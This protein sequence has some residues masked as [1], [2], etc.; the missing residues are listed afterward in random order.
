M[1]DPLTLMIDLH[2]DIL[3]FL[4]FIIAFVLWMMGTI[5]FYFNAAYLNK[6]DLNPPSNNTV[7][8]PIIEVL[9][10]SNYTLSI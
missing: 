9:V 7:A 5:I 6:M 8:T 4:I 1:I 10:A 3:F 2:H